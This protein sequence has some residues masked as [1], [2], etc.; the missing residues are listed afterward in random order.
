MR[1]ALI[2]LGAAT[3]AACASSGAS[4]PSEYETLSQECR[5]NGGILKPIP[6]ATSTNERANYACEIRDSTLPK[7]PG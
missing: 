4:G 3:L 6:G 2:L 5:A 7:T 1:F